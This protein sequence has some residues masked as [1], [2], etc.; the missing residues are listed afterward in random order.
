ML[1]D[2][3]ELYSYPNEWH[4]NNR[5][6]IAKVRSGLY[7]L[8]PDG[9]LRRGITTATTACAAINA[10]IAS[11]RGEI[12]Y[13]EVMTPV[14]LRVKVEVK[15]SKGFA[16]VKKFAG[17]HEFDVTDGI[18]FTAKLEGERIT[19]GYGI[20]IRGGKKAVSRDA[21]KQILEN[22]NYYAAKYHYSG[23]VLVEVPE[24]EKI[25]RKTKNE[26][27]GIRGGISILGTTGFVEPWCK[28]LVR[29]KIEI[30]K[31]YERIAVTTGRKAWLYALKRYIGY[32]PFVF[33]VHLDEILKEHPGEKIIVGFPKL[34]SIWA[35]GIDRIEEKAAEY[36]A[37]V[38]VIDD[39]MDCWGWNLQRACY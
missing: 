36:N 23:G 5:E 37:K 20:G 24:G 28:K 39:V 38:E 16:R 27:L 22:F 21:M 3:I 26:K 10:A 8:T 29:T 11:L 13:I 25:A 33:G 9:F 18:E 31:Q 1:R 12:E 34:L 30:A 4:R 35:G 2:P 15:A 32:Q 17:D 6:I 19:F 14:G 7:I